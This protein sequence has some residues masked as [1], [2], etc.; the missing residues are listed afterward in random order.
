[1][2]LIYK[3]YSSGLNKQA[4]QENTKEAMSLRK[5]LHILLDC[6]M[7]MKPI[8]VLTLL[9]KVYLVVAHLQIW[10]CLKDTPFIN[11]L[12]P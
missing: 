4:R 10:V 12:F 8:I 2:L 5:Y 1:M 9:N 3:F 6:I 11:F 7:A